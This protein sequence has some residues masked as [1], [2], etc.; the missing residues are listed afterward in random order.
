[1][2]NW[3]RV[4]MREKYMTD[5]LISEILPGAKHKVVLPGHSTMVGQEKRHKAIWRASRAPVS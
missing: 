1:M 2:I 5:F 4:K 3:V